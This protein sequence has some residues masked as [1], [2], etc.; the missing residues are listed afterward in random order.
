MSD[1]PRTTPGPRRTS[2]LP[3]AT[4]RKRHMQP[5]RVATLDVRHDFQDWLGPPLQRDARGFANRPLQHERSRVVGNAAHHVEPA[6][7]P[8]QKHRATAHATARR[9]IGTHALRTLN[10]IGRGSH[11]IKPLRRSDC[12]RT[13]SI[14]C[15][16]CTFA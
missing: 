6:R 13:G 16:S 11:S 15:R 9:K 1:R 4:M 8:R 7:R 10:E 3:S 2:A 14:S 5:P 12:W